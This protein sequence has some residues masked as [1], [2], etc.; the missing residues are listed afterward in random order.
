[1]FGSQNDRF[2]GVDF[3][4]GF[5]GFDVCIRFTSRFCIFV[6]FVFGVWDELACIDVCIEF[7]SCVGIEFSG[8]S[9]QDQYIDIVLK[10][11]CQYPS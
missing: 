8:W 11:M 2:A 6:G 9:V 7:A 10:T 3:G 1:V 4:I 5:A